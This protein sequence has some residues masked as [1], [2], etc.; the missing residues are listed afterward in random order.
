MKKKTYI[1]VTLVDDTEMQKLNKK[2][3]GRDYPTDVLSFNINSETPDG[4][5]YL[6]DIV[7][8][9]DQAL[10]QASEYGNDKEHELADLVAHG[11]LHLLGVHHDDDDNKSVHGIP[12]KK[13]KK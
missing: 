3:L 8:N 11:V 1:S 4:S 5:A 9:E 2:H 12:V 13:V 10:R 6:G 7:V